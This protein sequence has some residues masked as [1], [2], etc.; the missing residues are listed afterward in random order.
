M[1]LWHWATD[2]IY[3]ENYV[4]H[5]CKNSFNLGLKMKVWDGVLWCP[6]L[7]KHVVIETPFRWKNTSNALTFSEGEWSIWESI[8]EIVGISCIFCSLKDREFGDST[9]FSTSRNVTP[10]IKRTNLKELS[11]FRKKKYHIN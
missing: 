2:Q 11:K 3:I 10:I 9:S 4:I 1:M 6:P 8:L 7:L 5:L